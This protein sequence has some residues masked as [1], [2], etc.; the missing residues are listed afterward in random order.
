MAA[1]SNLVQDGRF[2]WILFKSHTNII[3]SLG[4]FRYNMAFVLCK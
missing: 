3:Y 2:V 1:N 4:V